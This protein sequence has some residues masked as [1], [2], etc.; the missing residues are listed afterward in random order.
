MRTSNDVLLQVVAEHG[1]VPPPDVIRDLV[2]AAAE[3]DTF[4]SSD[5]IDDAL[6]DADAGTPAG[7]LNDR[8]LSDVRKGPQRPG[9]S[10]L[11]ACKA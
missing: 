10:W 7:L 5:L 8:F 4:L 6:A 9:R 11:N 2:G 1:A 3:D